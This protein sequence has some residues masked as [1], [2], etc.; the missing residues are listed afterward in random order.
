MQ[1]SAKEF[2]KLCEPK[3]NK[4]RANLVFQSWLKDIRVNVVD[5]N[6]TLRETNQLIKDFT[7]EYSYSI[8]EFYMGMV[9]EEEQIFEDLI[10]YLENAFIYV[11]T[12]S[13]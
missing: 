3:L 6:L 13:E 2:Y 5:Q 10:N 12:I 9:T 4:P 1:M 8:V 7:A 11:E